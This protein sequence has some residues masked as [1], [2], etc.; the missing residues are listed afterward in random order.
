VR[1][2]KMAGKSLKPDLNHPHGRRAMAVDRAWSLRETIA[3]SLYEAS[4]VCRIAQGGGETSAFIK[5]GKKG[6]ALAGISAKTPAYRGLGIR[7][8]GNLAQDKGR[9]LEKWEA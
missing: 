9:E 1:V 3:I 7:P 6:P 4:G 8:S 2:G 5:K